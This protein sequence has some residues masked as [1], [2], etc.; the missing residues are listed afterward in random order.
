MRTLAVIPA[1]DEEERI[2]D[3]VRR[4][5]KFLGALVVD[6][7]SSD[8]T[9]AAA[10]AAGAEVERHPVNRGKSAALET[11]FRAALRLG[12]EA[13]V[14]LDADGQHLPEE[15][16]RFLEAA[17]K[18]ADV[19]VG[20]RMRDVRDMPTVRRWTN[21]TTSR[22]VSWLARTRLYDSQSGFRLFRAEVLRRVPV[23]AGRFAGESEILIRAGRAG[24]RIAEVPVSTVYFEGR[25]SR[26]DPVRDTIRF[27][28]LVSKYL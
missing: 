22:I 6:D 26:I 10:A 5:R 20:C 24:F 19:V 27:F 18:G 25:Q 4:V 28:R 13:V 16:P 15:I 8:R 7:G 23:T 3:V 14:T 1:F 21:Q 2:G 9:S 11:G 12:F 17:A